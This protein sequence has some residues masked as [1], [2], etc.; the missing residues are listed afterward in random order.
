MRGKKAKLIRKLV[1]GKVNYR[2]KHYTTLANGQVIDNASFQVTD[3]K[4]KT[5]TIS[6]RRL[7]RV[8]KKRSKNTP[9]KTIRKQIELS[10]K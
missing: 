9:L 10:T 4:N 2:D 5:K 6:L 1:Y 8:L 7:Y 3:E